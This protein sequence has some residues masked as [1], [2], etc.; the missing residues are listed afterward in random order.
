MIKEYQ[1]KIIVGCSG[2]ADSMCLADQVIK[3]SKDYP[4]TTVTL[5]YVDHG[6]RAK[7]AEE[8]K[9]VKDFAYQYRQYG[10]N[11]DS[12]VVSVKLDTKGS[13]EEEAR[14]ARYEA[15]RGAAERLKADW[16]FLAHT[17][18][19]Q[20]E[21][22]LM[23]ILRGTGVVGLSG[24]QEKR[25]FFIRPLLKWDRKDT[26]KYCEDNYISY[27]EDPMNRDAAYTR[28]RIRFNWLPA[29]REE[30]PNVNEALCRL[31][32]SATE[33]REFLD[34]SARKEIDTLKEQQGLNNPTFNV[35]FLKRLPKALAKHILLLETQSKTGISIELKQLEAFYQFILEPSKGEKY[36]KMPGVTIRRSYDVLHWN[37]ES[38]VPSK[39]KS[40]KK[41]Y[42]LRL[43]KDGDKLQDS[44][45]STL[46]KKLRVPRHLRKVTW[47]VEDSNNNIVWVEYIGPKSIEETIF[48]NG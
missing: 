34:F 11:V 19:D 5:L 39:I 20:A 38:S 13:V 36:L 8:G 41:S 33:V 47:V 18:S 42:S 3:S 27:V 31:S 23:R 2:G 29:L 21:T 46:Q 30:N 1:G 15:F 43:F 22:L 10:Y 4:G 24:I 44:K 6:L 16:V 45:V 48:E 17:K 37:P 32:T 26:E 35:R 12:L 40:V 28:S 9:K 7:S 14:K 25:E